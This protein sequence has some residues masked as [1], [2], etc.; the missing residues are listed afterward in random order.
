VVGY[1]TVSGLS[2]QY[3]RKQEVGFGG[4]IEHGEELRVRAELA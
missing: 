2:R 1:P 4:V 3:M